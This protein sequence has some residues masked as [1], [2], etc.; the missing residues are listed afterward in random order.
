[1]GFHNIERKSFWYNVLY[2]YVKFWH[3]VVFYRKVVVL[4]K[5]HVPANDPAIF[6]PNHQNALMDALALLFTVK[7]QLVFMA[8]SDIFKKFAPVLYFLKILPIY[9]IRDGIESLKKNQAVF[10]KTVDVLNAGNGLVILP[11]GNH[12]NERRLRVLK[13]GFARI[14][15]QTLEEGNIE[16][17]LKIVPVGLD[18]TD[19]VH[20]RSRLLVNF[21][22]P[23]DVAAF[24]PEYRK[25]PAVGLNKIKEVLAER[26]KRLI[27]H[28][29]SDRYYDFIDAWRVVFRKKVCEWR[30][31]DCNKEEE[32]FTA[33][34]FFVSAL[35]RSAKEYPEKMEHL[36][37]LFRELQ[38]LLSSTKLDLHTWSRHVPRIMQV[39]LFAG[40]VLGFPLFLYGLVNHLGAYQLPYYFSRKVPDKTFHSSFMYVLT[41]LFFPLF[42]ILQTVAVALF[43]DFPFGWLYYLLSLPFAAVVAW[44]WKNGLQLFILSCRK[45]RFNR[46]TQGFHVNT[47]Y[48]EIQ[49][50]VSALIQAELTVRK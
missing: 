40:L 41:M 12:K 11:E 4:N 32:A 7:R 29:E 42:Y 36:N 14:A 16:G 8:R 6:T 20:C 17:T 45:R 30:K 19:Y 28:I 5:Y 43:V 3:H 23:I 44:K 46:N 27:I 48:K 9:R 26:I 2:F 1:M 21:G 25:N 31:L 13:K 37:I 39:P 47:L 49:Q 22:E 24:L 34:R 35:N 18:Y 15:F 10:N 33:D 38:Q 50:L